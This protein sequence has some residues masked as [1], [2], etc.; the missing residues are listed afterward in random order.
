MM[1]TNGNMGQPPEKPDGDNGEEPPARP[2]D[3]NT[4]TNT[5]SNT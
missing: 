4:K 1:Q 2:E 3:S 5:N